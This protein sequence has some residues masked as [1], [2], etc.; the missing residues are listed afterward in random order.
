MTVESLYADSLVSGSVSSSGNALGTSNGTWT[1]DTGNV[2]W[3][4]QFSLGDPSGA[5]ANGTHTINVLARKATGTGTPSAT[6]S[7]YQ[8]ASLIATVSSNVS[9]TSATSQTLT[10]TFDSSLLTDLTDVRVQVATTAAGG[11]P[12]ARA[13]VQIDSIEWTGD[14]ASVSSVTA[15]APTSWNITATVSAASA[16]SWNNQGRATDTAAV[17]WNTR[18][19][20]TDEAA[21]S[22]STL[23]KAGIK[24]SA[25][26]WSVLS[27]IADSVATSW[28]T[29]AAVTKTADTT[30][31]T[32]VPTQPTV[33]YWNGVVES[34][35]TISIW[36]GSAEVP[37]ATMS[38]T[39]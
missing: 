33:T 26:S 7:V 27:K 37:I 21:A 15:T 6:I 22:W 34:S 25:T 24:T 36:D 4:A 20:V 1:S 30:W 10:G 3:T 14:F 39:E 32:H 9:V 16:T 38:V 31:N 11:S 18:M 12:S 19:T 8:G 29:R 2:S 17:A 23:I 5:V 13:A 28:L 35:V